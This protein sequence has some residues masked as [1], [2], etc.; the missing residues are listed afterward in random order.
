MA[1][2]IQVLLVDDMDGG[3]ATDTVSF[4]LDGHNYEIDVSDSNAAGLRD[5]LAKFITHARVV[6]PARSR[7]RGHASSQP[8]HTR[9]ENT[10]IREWARLHGFKVNDRG[11]IPE[12]I[13]AEY[14]AARGSSITIGDG[15]PVKARGKRRDADMGEPL[16]AD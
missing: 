8:R 4:G 15:K 13:A 11:R 6:A 5:P 10:A 1:Q 14:E 12:D 7:R 3:T 2:Q 9:E 16:F